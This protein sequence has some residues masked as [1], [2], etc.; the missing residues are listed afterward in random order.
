[1]SW[2]VFKSGF[3]SLNGNFW[4]GLE[5]V[6]QLTKSSPASLRI[7]MLITTGKWVS[8]E[9]SGFILDAETNKY[10]IHVTGFSGDTGDIMTTASAM[11]QNGMKFTTFDSDN[12]LNS[13]NCAALK[14]GGFWYNSCSAVNLHGS[15]VSYGVWLNGTGYRLSISRMMLKFI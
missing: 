6:Y 5:K 1:M 3:G 2:P 11:C 7:E 4:L 13:G 14:G 8:A 10:A 9:Y 12:D 15:A